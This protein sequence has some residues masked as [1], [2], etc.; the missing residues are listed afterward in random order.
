MRRLCTGLLTKLTARSKHHK[1]EDPT[2]SPT[3]NRVVAR[4]AS[5]FSMEVYATR[6]NF[7][8]DGTSWKPFHHDS[9][10]GRAFFQ[11][12]GIGPAEDFTVGASFG[13][14]RELAF[15]HVESGAQFAFPQAN[16]D[17]FAFDGVVNKTFQHGVPRVSTRCGPRFSVIAWGRRVL[18]TKRNAAADE[19]GERDERGQLVFPEGRLRYGGYVEKDAGREN[20]PGPA[21]SEVGT[22]VE[23]FVHARKEEAS[24]LASKEGKN[25]KRRNQRVAVN[26]G[27]K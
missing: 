11:S 1:F 10:A 14:T 8:A 13:S 6:L 16:G 12:G 26:A 7:Y 19:I 21:M 22:M 18:L 5:Y 17:I 25:G 23:T 20:A 9:H 15:L 2:I 24:A 4:L 3:F 27:R